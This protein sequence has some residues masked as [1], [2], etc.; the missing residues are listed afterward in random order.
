MV[1]DTTSIRTVTS[2]HSSGS[3]TVV[4]DQVTG[5]AVNDTLQHSA[6]S[7]SGITTV[8]A[9]NTGTKTLT[10]QGVSIAGIST[11]TQITVTHATDT[12]TDRGLGFT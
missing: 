6:F 10:F 12:N 2:T 1:G 8:T 7:L 5:I 9:I 4:V 3:S 11:G